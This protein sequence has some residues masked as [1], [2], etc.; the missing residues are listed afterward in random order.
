MKEQPLPRRNSQ[1]HKINHRDSKDEE[2][3]NLKEKLSRYEQDLSSKNE[4]TP[5]EGGQ[6]S[7]SI[8]PPNNQEIIEFI[9]KTMQ[10]LENYKL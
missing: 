9:T 3:K 4:K 1:H 8:L 10:S 7:K 6:T 2:I 5:Q